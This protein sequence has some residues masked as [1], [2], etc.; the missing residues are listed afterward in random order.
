ME[1]KE[2]DKDTRENGP[3]SMLQGSAVV[4]VGVGGGGGGG[5]V[6]IVVIA[7][8]HRPPTQLTTIHPSTY[9]FTTFFI[10]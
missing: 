2:L 9:P 7:I 6:V 1:E 3:T 4:D 8:T 10:L 5:G